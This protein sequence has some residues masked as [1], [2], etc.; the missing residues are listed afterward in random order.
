MIDV[1]M[2]TAFEQT[3]RLD[4]RKVD[5]VMMVGC[6]ALTRLADTALSKRDME[7]IY[8]HR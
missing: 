3:A 2:S 4:D 1:F 5:L 6:C 7:E 8:I